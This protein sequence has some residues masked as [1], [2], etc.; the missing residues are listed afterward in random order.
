MSFSTPM[1]M[2]FNT[3]PIAPQQ[4]TASTIA[5][6]GL[7]CMSLMKMTSIHPDTAIIEPTDKSKPAEM[8]VNRMPMET[9]NSG[10]LVSSTF[11]TLPT[12]KKPDSVDPRTTTRMTNVVSA[13]RYSRM[14]R[15]ALRVRPVRPATKGATCPGTNPMDSARS[16]PAGRNPRAPSTPSG[17][18]RT[19]P[20]VTTPRS[21]WTRPG[22]R[23]HPLSYRQPRTVRR[24]R[25]A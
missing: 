17:V 3:P 9:R 20:S 10:A 11:C 19:V 16:P 14:P 18:S 6:S 8:R 5:S 2:P 1:E 25:P 23:S 7:T 21:A 15:P 4:A 22:T 24:R 13:P 12:A